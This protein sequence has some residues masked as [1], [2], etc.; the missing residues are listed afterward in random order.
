LGTQLPKLAPSNDARRARVEAVPV[1]T[2]DELRLWLLP[3][4]KIKLSNICVWKQLVRLG[5]TLKK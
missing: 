5:L 3:E 2:I 4:H 1:T